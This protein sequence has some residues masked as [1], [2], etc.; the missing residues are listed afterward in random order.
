MRWE[1]QLIRQPAGSPE[2]GTAGQVGAPLPLRGILRSVTTPAFDGITFHEVLSKSA[3]NR[4]PEAS[5]MPFRWTVNPYRGCSHACVYCFARKT[6]SYLDLD[7]GAD[8]D[9]QLVVK[10]NIAEVLAAELRRPSWAGEHVALGTNTDPY[11]R[12]EGRY[13][14]MPGII[15]ALAGSGTPFSILTKGTLL[16]RDLE[17]LTWAARR[18]PVGVGLSIAMTDDSLSARIE[19]GTP[20]PTARLRLLRRLV[21]AGVDASVM[22]MPVLP[23]LSD[24]DECLD[25]LCGSLA[26]AGAS[27]V[28]AGPLHLRPGARE[29]YFAWLR[30]HRPDLLP[31]YSRLFARG[32]TADP[33]Y[34]SWLAGRI[35]HFR[36]RHGLAAG[37]GAFRE[38]QERARELRASHGHA[39][40]AAGRGHAAAGPGSRSRSR[41]AASG[42]APAGQDALF[43]LP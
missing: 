13:R 40:A 15:R 34:R 18:V 14:L 43:T 5:G 42:R 38:A 41:A 20:S 6:H 17:L 27:S 7:T 25:A 28:T 37:G 23:W 39:D 1:A 3:L 31:G 10:V 4:V 26:A 21:D 19:P 30:T 12:A 32:S 11:Q 22:A 8:F 29:W 35:R 36:T 9:A 2:A 24:S 16:A 33:Q